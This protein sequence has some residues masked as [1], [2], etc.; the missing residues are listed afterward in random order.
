MKPALLVVLSIAIPLACAFTGTLVILLSN[1]EV[2]IDE[3][4]QLGW[5]GL[6]SGLAVGGAVFWAFWRGRRLK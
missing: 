6:T 1:P 5:L 3:G 2:S 4:W